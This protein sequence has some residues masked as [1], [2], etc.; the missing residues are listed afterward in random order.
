MTENLHIIGEESVY[1]FINSF[2]A[3][4]VDSEDTIEPEVVEPLEEVV[5]EI[6]ELTEDEIYPEVIE[7]IVDDEVDEGL[8]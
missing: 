7:E 2:G 3:P 4:V 1:G 5:E 6:V 8:E